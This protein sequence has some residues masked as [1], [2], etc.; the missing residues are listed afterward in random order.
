MRYA[1]SYRY[2]IQCPVSGTKYKDIAIA[3]GV[4]GVESMTQDEYRAAAINAVKQLSIDVGIPEKCVKIKKEDFDNISRDALKDACYP[5][6]PREASQEQFKE[7][8]M[9]LM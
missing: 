5:G 6:S 1:S 9:K 2:G 8:F 3:L 7:L 4:K